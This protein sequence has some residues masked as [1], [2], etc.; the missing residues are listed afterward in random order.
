MMND[1]YIDQLSEDEGMLFIPYG[2]CFL[3][4]V[5]LL[6]YMPYGQ[7]MQFGN[8]IWIFRNI[9]KKLLCC[10]GFVGRNLLVSKSEGL[11]LQVLSKSKERNI[12]P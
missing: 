11:V 12:S 5:F 8:E 4:E 7:R 1:M 3:C 10:S 2:K 6:I 9:A